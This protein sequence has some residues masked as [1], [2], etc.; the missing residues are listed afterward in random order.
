MDFVCLEKKLIIEVDGK[1]HDL[2]EQREEDFMRT[3]ELSRIGFNLIRFDN[4]E[5]MNNIENVLYQI[6]EKLKDRK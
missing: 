2:P 6:K 5:I 3:E 4:V 1:Y